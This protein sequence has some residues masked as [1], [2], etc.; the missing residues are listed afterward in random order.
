MRYLFIFSFFVLLF[1]C[2][3]DNTVINPTNGD[4]FNLA[5][6]VVADDIE[7]VSFYQCPNIDLGD[8]TLKVQIETTN[9][10][11][12]YESLF[13]M[14][15]GFHFMTR[16]WN[17]FWTTQG[18]LTYFGDSL[19]VS[20]LSIVQNPVY[21]DPNDF[22]LSYENGPT[23]IDQLYEAWTRIYD[24]EIV[25]DFRSGDQPKITAYSVYRIIPGGGGVIPV[26]HFLIG[27]RS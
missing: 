13:K 11:A 6:F 9:Q 15:N 17:S 19:D 25:R 8:D 27:K 20:A 21:Y 7:Y 22:N 4:N 14:D 1:G 2:K 24:L 3:K 16:A 18:T 12:N 23:D 26:W 10:N 5:L